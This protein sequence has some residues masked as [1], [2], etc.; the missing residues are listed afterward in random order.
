M[1]GDEVH[2]FLLFADTFLEYVEVVTLTGG[3]YL[4]LGKDARESFFS[5]TCM[6]A[7]ATGS[8]PHGK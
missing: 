8:T 3:G 2:A 1:Q 5:I 4:T 7:P 6:N